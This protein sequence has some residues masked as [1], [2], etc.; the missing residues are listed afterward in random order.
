MSKK[1]KQMLMAEIGEHLG[2]SKNLLLVDVSKLEA[3]DANTW[4]IALR[5]S[6]ISALTVKNTLAR[7]VLADRG[8][9]GLDSVLSGPTTLVWGGEDVVELSK[10]IAKWAKELEALEI[11]GA[12]I[13]GNILDHDAVM[14]LSKSPGRAELLSEIAGLM[15]APAR[16]IAG[17][18]LGPGGRVS[19]AV[20]AASEKEE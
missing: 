7:R 16:Q 1:V 2:E 8:V 5:G 4:R 6:N 17:A 11:K 14:Q 12:T 9:E 13:E 10:S 20:K 3:N 19:G 15:L 18:L